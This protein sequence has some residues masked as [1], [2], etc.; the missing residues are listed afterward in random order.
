MLQ[1]ASLGSGS[2][3]NALLV[4]SENTLLLL[5]CG[6]TLKETT[7]RMQRLGLSPANLDG[8]LISHEHGDHI[9]GVGPLSRKFAKPVWL[10]HGTYN[11]LRDN[12]FTHSNLISA[13]QSFSIGDM[14]IDPFPTPHDAA[15]SCQ[16][17]FSY[18]DT[19]FACLT[20]LGTCTPHVEEKLAGVAGILVES[21]YDEDMLSNGPYP[22][23]LQA[24]IRSD[25][26]HLGNVQAG[27]LIKRIDHAGMQTILLGHLSEQ[28]NSDD[29][30]AST[31]Q[32]YLPAE[33]QR[34]T[35]LQQ[36]SC[37]AWFDIAATPL[38]NTSTDSVSKNE[39]DKALNDK[40][41]NE[42]ELAELA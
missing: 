41:L 32:K 9:R 19:K 30:A 36:H 28:N 33:D 17:V 20:D 24:R 6:F 23:S 18:K 22:V 11:A 38:E 35:V 8:I 34:V 26:G 12:R 29:A 1:V 27:E 21:N 40:A 15:E 42:E 31:M 2:A 37:S 4:R 13:H 5:D 14:H 25:F 16:Y 39:T 10:T 7:A 3:G